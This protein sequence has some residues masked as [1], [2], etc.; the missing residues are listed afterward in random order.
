MAQWHNVLNWLAGTFQTEDSKNLGFPNNRATILLEISLS[1]HK[2]VYDF[3]LLHARKL[4][5]TCQ[6]VH[7]TIKNKML[8]VSPVSTM[9][10]YR[11]W[12]NWMIQKKTAGH[13]K[14]LLMYC[15]KP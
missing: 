11:T 7:R 14:L 8:E 10:T 1:N 12:S 6:L 3:F 15:Y 4:L 9:S 2:V 13:L 5:A